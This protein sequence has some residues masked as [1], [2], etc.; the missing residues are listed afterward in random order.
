[1]GTHE[2][3]LAYLAERGMSLRTLA[4]K[5]DLDVRT[6]EYAASGDRRGSFDTWLRM[7]DALGAGVDDISR[8]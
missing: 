3:L 1:M 4:R 5:A 6:V 2:V 8:A 7:A